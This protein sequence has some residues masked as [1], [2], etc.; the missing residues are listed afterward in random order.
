MINEKRVKQMIKMAMFEQKYGREYRPLVHYKRK[1]YVS[2]A[3]TASF[4]AGTAFFFIVYG[5]IIAAV[6][7]SVI[8]NLSKMVIMMLVIIGVLIYSL[9]IFIHVYLARTAARKKYNRARKM[10][11][12]LAA[13]YDNLQQIYEEEELST[14]VD[15]NK[16]S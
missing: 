8:E 2:M 14:S 11:K 15:A 9:Y 5:L 7:G 1:D 12:V 16:K 10:I 4:F 6:L 13:E 3:G